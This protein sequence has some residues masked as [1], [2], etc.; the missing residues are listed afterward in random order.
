MRLCSFGCGDEGKYFFKSGNVC[1][2][3]SS[4]QCEKKKSIDSERKKGTFSGIPSWKMG[5]GVWN[6]GLTKETNL[7]LK[8]SSEKFKKNYKEGKYK[9]SN[10]VAPTIKG[11]LRRRQKISVTMKKNPNAGGYRYGSGRGVKTWYE[12]KI[13]GR[14]FLDSSWELEYAKYL[15]KNNIKWTRNLTKFSYIWEGINRYYIPDFYIEE[16]DFYVEVKGYKTEKDEGK[17]KYFPHKLKVLFLNELKD[18][19]L[20]VK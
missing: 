6:K 17:W 3:P 10:G 5:C 2:S 8:K 14:V 20:N 16:H 1:C 13:A 7:I 12:S 19:G 9:K 15:D 4:N 18:L 11:E